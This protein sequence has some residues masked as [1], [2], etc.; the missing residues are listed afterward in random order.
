MSENLNEMAFPEP[1]YTKGW[2]GLQIVYVF[3][4]A[5]ILTAITMGISSLAG[6]RMEIGF[7][8]EEHFN[9]IGKS[10]QYCFALISITLMSITLIELAFRR[11][12][13]LI[14]NVLIGCSLCLFY[15]LLVS[16]SEHL[17]FWCAYLIVSAMTIGLIAWFINAITRSK[18]ASIS[19]AGILTVEYGLILLLVY[20]GSMMLL[21]GSILLFALIG[22]AMYLTLR[23]KVEDEELILK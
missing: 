1:K 5:G 14:Q 18:K 20:L 15:L 11:G 3:V 4:I 8:N 13:N 7:L 10:A 6:N 17:P 12:A 16:V 22:L 9:L 2:L 21:V 19:I 23:L